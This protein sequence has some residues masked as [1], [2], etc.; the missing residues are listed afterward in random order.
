MSSLVLSGV[1]KALGALL[2]GGRLQAENPAW[3]GLKHTQSC[4]SCWVC[5]RLLFDGK[6]GEHFFPEM[7]LLILAIQSLLM[8]RDMLRGHGEAGGFVFPAF[9]M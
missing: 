3:Q 1:G 4:F 2:Q 5:W 7:S 6:L 9:I 8:A